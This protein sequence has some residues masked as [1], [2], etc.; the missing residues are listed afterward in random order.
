MSA[1]RAA[2]AVRP[3]VIAAVGVDYANRF[4]AHLRHHGALL[5]TIGPSE[6]L[7]K[8]IQLLKDPLHDPPH[9]T[10]E[11]ADPDRVSERLAGPDRQHQSAVPGS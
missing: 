10:Q 5:A 4:R 6:S 2:L 7:R 3:S 11:R 8:S 9:R 1:W